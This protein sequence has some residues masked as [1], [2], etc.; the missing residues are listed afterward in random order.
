MIHVAPLSRLHETVERSGARHVITLIDEAT[1]VPRPPGVPPENH[2]RLDFHDIAAPMEGKT[3][4]ARQHVESVLAFAERWDRAT[5]LV[6]H[7]WA[8]ISRSTAV[9]Y[10]LSCAF[11]PERCEREIALGL[12][13][14]APSATPNPLL[15]AH[16][17]D[18]LGRAGR[19]RSAIAFIG[20]GADAFEGT[21]FVLELERDPAGSPRAA[22][23]GA[24][25]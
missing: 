18:H 25:G 11:A 14:A 5:P 19:M 22:G 7:C 2:F 15:V 6:V 1:V 8:G 17:D 12:R 10:I 3:P 23:P 16:A 13:R 24:A 21:P 9:A 20:R 4:P